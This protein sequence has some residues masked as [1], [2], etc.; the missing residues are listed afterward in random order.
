MLGDL[1]DSPD[2]YNE[3]F[4]ELNGGVL[5]TELDIDLKTKG[6]FKDKLAE[7][8]DI[9]YLDTT[10]EVFSVENQDAKISFI[11]NGYVDDKISCTNEFSS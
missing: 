7:C 6:N 10:A 5:G 1:I 9:V 3:A 8:T 4:R 2:T 11:E